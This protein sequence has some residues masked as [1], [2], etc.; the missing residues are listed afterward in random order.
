MRETM[1]GVPIDFRVF[2]DFLPR[3]PKRQSPLGKT[4]EVDQDVSGSRPAHC[5]GEEATV[6][7][8]LQWAKSSVAWVIAGAV[9]T[10]A[11]T[12]P[13]RMTRTEPAAPG[14]TII[15]MPGAARTRVTGM[16]DAGDV[17]GFYGFGTAVNFAF[18]RNRHGEYLDVSPPGALTATAA[19]I[20]DQGVIVGAYRPAGS[21]ISIGYQLE[22]GVYTPIVFPG[23]TIT[24][25]QDINE[26]GEICGRYVSG[27]VQ[28]GFTLIDGVYTSYD[29]PHFP[30]ASTNYTSFDL[31]R[32][33]RSEL[34]IGDVRD[35]R[36]T[37]VQVHGVFIDRD[38]TIEVFDYPGATAT[39]PRG[40]TEGGAIVGAAF[41]NGVQHGFSRDQFGNFGLL[42]VPGA[43]ETRIAAGN[44]L[45][46]AG[47]SF[48]ANGIEHGFVMR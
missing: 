37:P 4:A 21:T 38:G 41:I 3:R 20:N 32:I 31:H 13:A 6:K 46:Y 15:D 27:G 43:D 48:V 47:G 2:A 29:I 1:P 22:N 28:H 26:R 33:G 7:P 40:L 44:N 12:L 23:A 18:V 45:G 10:S 36:F 42:D 11:T 30:G 35:A 9:L 24:D 14:V 19:G 5:A 17:V 16:N 34:M 8:N 39:L 25:P